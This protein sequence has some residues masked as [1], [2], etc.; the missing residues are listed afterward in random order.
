[1][2]ATADEKTKRARAFTRSG[3]E[4]PKQAQGGLGSDQR[5]QRDQL[6]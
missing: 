1:M 3:S 6:G 5:L 4:H 2:S